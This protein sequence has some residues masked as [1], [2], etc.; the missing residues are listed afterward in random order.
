MAMKI[1]AQRSMCM[2][3]ANN[4]FEKR[5]K[6]GL[7]ILFLYFYSQVVRTI[8]VYIRNREIRLSLECHMNKLGHYTF[9]AEPKENWSIER[10]SVFHLSM[11]CV[12]FELK[13]NTFLHVLTFK[14][15]HLTWICVSFWNKLF[16]RASFWLVAQLM[17]DF[18]LVG[19]KSGF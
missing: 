7:S 11:D 16:Q 6:K 2:D 18:I 9:N 14:K 17:T 10:E 13:N 4:P 8:F 19:V 5:K 1:Y 12:R 15:S 3:N